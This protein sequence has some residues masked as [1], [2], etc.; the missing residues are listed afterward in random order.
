MTTEHITQLLIFE[1]SPSPSGKKS[2]APLF[3]QTYLLKEASFCGFSVKLTRSLPPPLFF[4]PGGGIRRA[5]QALGERKLALLCNAGS[6][7]EQNLCKRLKDIR[8][9]VSTPEDRREHSPLIFQSLLLQCYSLLRTYR[10]LGRE[11]IVFP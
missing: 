4:D 11:I 6:G 5:V 7:G 3:L 2:N 8:A 1:V 10:D 9:K